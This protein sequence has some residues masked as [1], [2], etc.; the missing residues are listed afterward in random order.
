ME[1]L[2]TELFYEAAD[3]IGQLHR[4]HCIMDYLALEMDGWDHRGK[5]RRLIQKYEYYLDKYIEEIL[6]KKMEISFECELKQHEMA[7]FL[8]TECKFI[9]DIA[10]NV[11]EYL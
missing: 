3:D 11:S 10:L 8:N 9:Y 1:E 5:H 6:N 7:V 2:K 4:D